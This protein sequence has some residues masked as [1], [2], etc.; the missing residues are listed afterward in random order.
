MAVST[1]KA[2]W[3]KWADC[4]RQE[5]MV[6]LIP[7][8]TKSIESIAAETGS[9]KAQKTLK[10]LAFWR[11]CKSGASPNDFLNVAGFEIEFQEDEGR[12]V[13]E[14]TLKLNSTWLSIMQK[15]LDRAGKKSTS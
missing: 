14:V 9:T 6:A 1:E 11:S 13:S 3:K 10:S 8:V 5:M 7:Q 4:L 2:R 12:S 15:V